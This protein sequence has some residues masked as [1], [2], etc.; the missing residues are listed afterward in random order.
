MDLIDDA[1]DGTTAVTLDI[2]GGTIDGVTIATSDITVGSGKT[3]D[4]S[5]GTL[6]LA[7][8]QI[9]GDKVEGGTIASITLT[10]ADINGGTIDGTVIGGSSAAAVTATALTATSSATL[11]HS[12]ST[13]LSTTSTG[14]DVTGTITSDGLT[15]D[16]TDSVTY[17]SS[18]VQG[19]LVISR[20]NSVNTVN[21]VVGLEFDITGWSGS[22]TG[23]AG[24]SAIQTGS[25]TSSAALAFQTRNAGTI[26][27]RMRI[28]SNGDISFYEDTGTTPKFVWDASTEILDL[29]SGFT[30]GSPSNPTS[31]K[32]VV[33]VA[34]SATAIQAFEV[35]NRVNADF[36]FKVASN[37]VTGG[38]TI[39]KP[40]AFMTSNTE[41]MRIDSS[42]NVGI[43]TASPDTQLHVSKSSVSGTSYDSNDLITIENN[44]FAAINMISSASTASTLIF[45]D[46]T[47]AVGLLQYNHSDNS[48]RFNTNSAERMRIDSSGNVGIG[49]SSPAAKLQVEGDIRLSHNNPIEW[50]GTA[51]S[52]VGNATT[53]Y[54]Q[55]NTASTERMRI[56]SSGNV[57]VG[58]TS[59][60]G[61]STNG[62]EL[63]N[64]G[65]VIATKASGISGYFGRTSTDGEIIRFYR[66][67]TTVGSIG[68]YSGD[69]II[70]T[71]DVH[72]R[73]EDAYD[74]ISARNADGTGRDAA[75]SLGAASV[76]FKD[77]YLS[78]GL[79]GDTLTFS[80]L[81]GTERMRIDS[82]GNLMVG[83]TDTDPS[84]DT[85]GN[86]GIALGTAS[87][88]YISLARANA[89]PLL[90]N[91]IGT[92]GENIIVKKDG[93]TVGSIGTSGSNIYFAG[94][95]TYNTGIRFYN[96][97]MNP[98]DNA[99]VYVDNGRDIGASNVRWDD[100]YATNGTIQTSDRNE[101]QDIDVLSE[102]ETRVAQACKGLL[103]KFRWKDAVAEKGDDARIHFGI[104]AQDL[105]DAFAA[106]GLDAGD[107]A[108]FIHSTWTDEE[109]GEE[110]SR[111]GVRYPELLA[112]IIAAL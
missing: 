86:G 51:Y 99:G 72:L 97:G 98:C 110:R 71:G 79:R 8:N 19:D 59:P 63:R 104:I 9:S 33:K 49:T 24:I 101:K 64:D 34:D 102:A 23:V 46:A 85:S 61:V 106:E 93:S 31:S 62:V 87:S 103:R 30:V 40:I 66:D 39:A 83:T 69:L 4:V 15:V 17:S 16:N 41:R 45:S 55:F 74:L 65:I 2:N 20:K 54:L 50:G 43:G 92:D 89:T 107:Y 58:K 25:N 90:V 44:G 94:N 6:T 3:L 60:A 57:L 70:G 14:V 37:I 68:V 27:E 96:V 108:M 35:T 18:A 32:A 91:R 36:V 75:V 11:Q 76:R 1:L 100:I 21:Q 77:I 84:N 7:D 38:S 53:G 22:T 42:G 48:M 78:G 10:S 81:A 82:L 29:A 105:Q 111:M 109:T 56:D 13:K 112:F 52:I 80:N 95:A 47:R 67:S 5:A 88:C 26:A 73:F 12:A 28:A